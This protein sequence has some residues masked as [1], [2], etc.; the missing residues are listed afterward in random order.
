MSDDVKA[1]MRPDGK[2]DNYFGGTDKADG[3]GHGHVVAD[4][5]GRVDYAREAAQ[6][7]PGSTRSQR[8]STD[9][10]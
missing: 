9:R 5:N 2:T 1:A 7:L 6:H 4:Q 3:A 10:R 8:V